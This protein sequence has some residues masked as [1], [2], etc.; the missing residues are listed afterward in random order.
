[1]AQRVS[2]GDVISILGGNYDSSVELGPFIET[3][4]TLV[5]DLDSEDTGNLLNT[6]Q[7][8]RIEAYLAAHFYG[9]ADQFAMAEKAGR[10]SIDY[11]GKTDGFGLDG[12]F[13]GQTA[14]M[15]DKTG[16]LRRLSGGVQR[17]TATWLGKR[18]SQQT[19]YVD[20]D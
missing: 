4:T 7:L 2:D 20:R 9:H 17:A 18:K 12:T 14:M 6:Q 16:Y 11:Q 8:R 10:A 1:M 13:Y 5:D 3:A 15:I 19:D